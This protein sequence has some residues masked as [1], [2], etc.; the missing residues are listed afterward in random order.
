MIKQARNRLL[1]LPRGLLIALVTVIISLGL[2]SYAW[3]S[4]PYVMDAYLLLQTTR[5]GIILSSSF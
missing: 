2:A 4:L 3:V 1:S 5:F